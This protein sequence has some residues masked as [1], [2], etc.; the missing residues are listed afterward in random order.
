M[1]TVE[2]LSEATAH[3]N[4]FF[5]GDAHAWRQGLSFPDQA[6]ISRL[7]DLPEESWDEPG[8]V[9]DELI[10]ALRNQHPDLFSDTGGLRF[11]AAAGAVGGEPP[12]APPPAGEDS[13]DDA[14][15]QAPGESG[16][17]DADGLSGEAAEAAA[18]VDEA[19]EK[20]RTA[21][22][23][24]DES[25]IDA[26]LGAHAGSE[27]GK[28]QLLNVQESLI[29]AINRIEPTL[30]TAAGQEELHSFLHGKIH[31]ILGVVDSAELDSKSKAA[32]LDALG[33]RFDALHGDGA[34]GQGSSADNGAAPGEG[35]AGSSGSGPA[36]AAG[37]PG[38]AGAPGQAGLNDPLLEGLPSDPFLEGLGALAGP[39]MGALSGLPGMMGSMLPA[40]GGLAGGGGGL[41][42][43]DL[44]GAIGGAIREATDD[45]GSSLDDGETNLGDPGVGDGAGQ[46]GEHGDDHGEHDGE[47]EASGANSSGEAPGE[48]AAAGPAG[49][50][51]GEVQQ[52]GH[53]PQEP[54][55]DPKLVQLPNGDE[56]AADNPQLAA[57]GRAVLDG[58][59]VDDAFQQHLDVT[60]PPPGTPVT[61]AVSPSQLR[62]GDTGEFTD[63]RVMALGP[64]KVWDGSQV[65]PI[66]E[67][68]TGPNFLGWTRPSAQAQTPVGASTA[69]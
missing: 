39:G 15:G 58:A 69:N 1:A 66:S 35:T 44:G 32:V 34:G 37:A 10:G 4:G 41:P 28:Q 2:E 18:K 65:V 6:A 62:F 19:L 7:L 54:P 47:D 61:S 13:P 27:E 9:R 30:D 51:P 14:E 12:T 36:A 29:D 20:T 50:T 26:V 45:T 60:L 52:V 23:E 57:A 22:G 53:E 42:L 16:G 55:P 56:V 25:L 64:D 33:E 67:L 63:H 40:A 59:G 46:D 3:I 48:E 24:A 38:G 43:G 68:H 8:V 31:E 17:E 21:R 11:P 49:S 5:D